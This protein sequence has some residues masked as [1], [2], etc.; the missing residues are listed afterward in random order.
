MTLVQIIRQRP[1]LV[2]CFVFVVA[3]IPRLYNLTSRSAWM[4]EGRQ[5]GYSIEGPF[6]NRLAAKAALQQQPPLDYFIQSMFVKNFGVNEVGIRLHSALLGA[7]AASL[8]FALVL[9][10]TNGNLTASALGTAVFAFNPWLIR[11]SQEGRPISTA[12]LFSVLYL[13]AMTRFLH[14]K[15]QLDSTL[16]NLTVL[17]AVQTGFLLSVGFQPLVFLL[18]GSLSL[19][20]LLVNRDYRIKVLLVLG[21]TAIAASLALPILLLVIRSGPQY[22]GKHTMMEM[23]AA[24]LTGFSNLSLD[25]HLTY[26][27]KIAGD[28]TILFLVTMVASVANLAFCNPTSKD[29]WTLLYAATFLLL[30]PLVY[31][32]FF[33]SL[34]DYDIKLRYF[35][36]FAP[37]LVA[38][39]TIL[40]YHSLQAAGSLW[41]RW[42]GPLRFF[43]HSIL[44][45]VFGISFVGNFGKMQ[46]VYE[47]KNAEWNKMFAM[48]KRETGKH[49]VAYMMNL[50]RADEW[51][52][53][54]RC[55]M[56]YY[57]KNLPQPVELRGI[58]KMSADLTR[59]SKFWARRGNIFISTTY[60][61]KKINA[62]LFSD[63]NAVKVYP[64]YRLPTIK[65]TRG[66]DLR[67]RV[68]NV[69]E[70][71]VERLPKT[72]GNFKPLELLIHA[73]I[74]DGRLDRAKKNMALLATMDSKNKL[75][76][77]IAVF[78][79]KI[80]RTKKRK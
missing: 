30:Y 36:T 70:R 28:Y 4:D 40:I 31:E 63:M 1:H 5:V 77:K 69:L 45:L 17:V 73:D 56:F 80:D 18:V 20:P 65:I 21:T 52:P 11:Y 47:T 53:F 43:P 26:P 9:I 75:K 46:E 64:F 35:L 54:F 34:I 27:F 67:R 32:V 39:L 51:S 72:R 79:Q 33:K 12:V 59:D 3:L 7:L 2:M 76:R 48:L 13:H 49:G 42:H 24:I 15:I 25:A 22:V 66:K 37:A 16:K 61:S 19:L 60:G 58:R 23:I 71:I 50:V 41:S 6:G 74:K 62:S 14:S 55:R 10:L 44:A 29:R 68:I 78:K 38:G 8:F 57:P